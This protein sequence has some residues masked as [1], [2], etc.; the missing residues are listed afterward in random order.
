MALYLKS[1]NFACESGSQGLQ[2]VSY[3]EVVVGELHKI[4][5]KV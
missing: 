4:R 5:W 3:C 2:L 1:L